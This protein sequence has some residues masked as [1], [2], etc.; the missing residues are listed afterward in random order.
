MIILVWDS[1][2]LG[3]VSGD[4]SQVSTFGFLNKTQLTKLKKKA[5]RRGVWFTVLRRIDR[6]LIDLTIK[7]SDIVRSYNLVKSI[8]T[9]AR[10][11]QEVFQSKLAHRIKEIGIP[12]TRKLSLL[13]Q[14]WGNKGAWKWVNDANFAWYLTITKLN[15]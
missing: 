6:A 10:K 14:N 1:G 11:V 9:I 8:L 12:L 2:G 3:T 5:I 4:A 13:A 7:V 15:S